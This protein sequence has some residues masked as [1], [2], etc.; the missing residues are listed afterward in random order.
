[1]RRVRDRVNVLLEDFQEDT[2]HGLFDPGEGSRAVSLWEF[3]L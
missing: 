1:M 2:G 3:C